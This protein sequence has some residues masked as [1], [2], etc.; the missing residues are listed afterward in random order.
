MKSNRV[1]IVLL[2]LLFLVLASCGSHSSNNSNLRLM[3]AI[4]DAPSISVQLGTNP[5]LVTGCC[6]SSSR[7]T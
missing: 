1:Q 3:N 7:S 2:C 6:S 4:P 5:P